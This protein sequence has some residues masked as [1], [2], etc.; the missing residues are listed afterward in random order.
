[1]QHGDEPGRHGSVRF[2]NNIGLNLHVSQYSFSN[3][4][5]LHENLY[6]RKTR[7][8]FTIRVGRGI[9]Q[10]I[11]KIIQNH[12]ERAV[13]FSWKGCYFTSNLEQQAGGAYDEYSS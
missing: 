10:H 13:I 4:V 1:M 8:Y 2:E 12:D 7:F 5:K 11:E 6:V 3:H 9:P